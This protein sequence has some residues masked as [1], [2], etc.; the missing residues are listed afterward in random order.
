V[1]AALPLAGR[2]VLVTRGLEKE[3]RLPS[4]LEQAGA[5]VL[6]VPLI[7][8]LPLVDADDLRGALDR[9]R[10]PAVRGA[11]AW[12]VVTSETAA[13]MVAEAAGEPALAGIRVAAVG[14]ATAAAL[15]AREVETDVVAP[16]QEAESLA[17]EL[18]RIGVKGSRVL[19]IAAAGGRNVV[20]PA[21]ED[22][23]AH[24]EVVEAYRT[25]MP[26][27]AAGALR[28]EFAHGPVDAV[29]FTSGSTVRHFAAA[30][31]EPPQGCTAACIGSV[32]A[33]VARQ[34]GWERV[35]VADEHTAAGVVAV[36]VARVGGAHPLP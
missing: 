10:E 33:E 28:A 8:P 3:D 21:L 2:R 29:T 20:G 17:R 35:V 4:L 24:V 11:S 18:A 26:D 16:G 6:R 36:L 1:S 30:I 22:A 14:P 23:G 5:T 19:V 13:V 9:L 31:P 7:T 32:T 15:R 12:V 25:V 27:G 34:A